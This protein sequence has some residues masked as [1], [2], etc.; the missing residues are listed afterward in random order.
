MQDFTVD[1]VRL[2]NLQAVLSTLM[3]FRPVPEGLL[4]I[5]SHL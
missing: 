3:M 4:R 5:A 2:W 1:G